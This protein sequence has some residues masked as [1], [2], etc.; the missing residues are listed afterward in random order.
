MNKSIFNQILG[1][2]LTTERLQELQTTFEIFNAFGS[3]AGNFTIIEGC[4]LVG[5][6]VQNG[7]IFLNGELLEFKKAD[8]TPTSAVIIVETAVIRPFQTGLPKQ[9]YTKRHATF[10]TADISYPWTSFK[11]PMETKEIQEAL[12]RKQDKTSS[13]DLLAR[14]EILEKKNAIF[15]VGGGMLLWNK[16]ANQIPLGWRE[17]IN[18]EGRIPVGFDP[19]D[20]DFNYVGKVGGLKNKRLSKEEM[21]AHKHSIPGDF[22]EN[23]DD[24]KYAINGG[25]FNVRTSYTDIAGGP[26]GSTT[27]GPGQAFSLMNPF[28]VVIFIEYIG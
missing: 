4:N 20:I 26:P 27:E 10:G 23:D 28:R 5:T 14:I 19:K 8:V 21:P 25:E 16:P 12:D 22:D 9:I 13:G 24:G 15:Q 11:R 6:T 18:W 17:V 7:C 1:Y 2:P 3:L